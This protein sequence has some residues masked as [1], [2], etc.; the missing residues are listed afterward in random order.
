MTEFTV[1]ELTL[2]RVATFLNNC[3]AKYNFLRIYEIFNK[4][5]NKY[6]HYQ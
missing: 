5:N 6:M 3:T 2:C 1:M 4:T